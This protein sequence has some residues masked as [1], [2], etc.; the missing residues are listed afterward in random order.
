MVHEDESETMKAQFQWH[1]LPSL[2]GLVE[3]ALVSIHGPLAT[4]SCS[5]HSG[6]QS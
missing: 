5:C 2:P 3:L 6:T 4:K 1:G